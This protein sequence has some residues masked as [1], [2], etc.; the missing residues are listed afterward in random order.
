MF[1]SDDELA[2]IWKE[3]AVTYFMVMAQTFYRGT[4]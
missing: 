2:R 3:S 4:E 1:E